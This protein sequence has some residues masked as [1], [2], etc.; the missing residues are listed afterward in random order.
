MTTL[1]RAATRQPGPG[2]LTG[3]RAL[4]LTE[5]KA[6]HEQARERLIRDLTEGHGFAYLPDVPGYGTAVIPK[7]VLDYL[8][9]EL[10]R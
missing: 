8:R 9:K 10:A 7:D 1:Q 6:E 2:D 4:R 5:E 3:A